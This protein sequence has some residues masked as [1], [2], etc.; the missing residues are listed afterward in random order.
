MLP[1]DDGC[2]HMPSVRACT[3]ASMRKCY[4]TCNLVCERNNISGRCDV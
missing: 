2:G 4:I 1:A 3:S